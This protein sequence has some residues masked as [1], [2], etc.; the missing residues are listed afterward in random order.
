MDPDG[1]GGV[2]TI[3]T[4]DDV[5]TFS[6]GRFLAEKTAKYDEATTLAT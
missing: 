4:A 5:E 2:A 6:T 3:I 1:F